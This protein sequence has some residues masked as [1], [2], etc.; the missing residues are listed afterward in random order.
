MSIPAQLLLDLTRQ[1]LDPEPAIRERG[2]DVVTGM[3]RSYSAAEVNM[4]ATLL[5]LCACREQH[6]DTLEAQLHALFELGSSG[7]LQPEA[8]SRL[9]EIDVH[10]LPNDLRAYVADLLE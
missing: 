8:L 2:A 10:G 6:R 3:I 7:F 5:S 1:L 4:L 9:R